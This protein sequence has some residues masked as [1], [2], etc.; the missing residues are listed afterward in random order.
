MDKDPGCER[1]LLGNAKASAGFN[2]PSVITPKTE[3]SGLYKFRND[4]VLPVR[5]GL[6]CPDDNRSCSS[7]VLLLFLSF[8]TILLLFELANRP[9]PA[10]H[11]TIACGKACQ[12]LHHSKVYSPAPF[13]FPQI[14]SQDQ[15][16]CTFTKPTWIFPEAQ[17]DAHASEGCRCMSQVDTLK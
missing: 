3:S 6:S 11:W 10:Q 7:W 13:C 16:W 2:D 14:F 1:Q 12:Q 15:Q 17:R 5:D 4:S 8:T 9:W